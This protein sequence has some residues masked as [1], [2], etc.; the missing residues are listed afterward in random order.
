MMFD[1]IVLS[2]FFFFFFV[3]LLMVGSCS[4]E[5]MIILQIY[6]LNCRKSLFTRKQVSFSKKYR[7]KVL[8]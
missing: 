1:D 2:F 5:C 7:V 8:G 3:I 4:F 6:F